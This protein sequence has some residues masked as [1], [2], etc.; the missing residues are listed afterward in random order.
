[1]HLCNE[2]RVRANRGEVGVHEILHACVDRVVVT[3][4][5]RWPLHGTPA[6]TLGQDTQCLLRFAP[7]YVAQHLQ[8]PLVGVR[9]IL[10]AFPA[11]ISPAQQL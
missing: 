8:R 4:N 3:V 2:I 9:P 1:M 10:T 11:V 5:Q 6:W 7:L